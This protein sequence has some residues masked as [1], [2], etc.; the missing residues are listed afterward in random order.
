MVNQYIEQRG[1]LS[2]KTVLIT[3]CSSGIGWAT[4]KKL[5]SSG[6]RVFATARRSEDIS[7]IVDQGWHA[8]ELD[9]T[10]SDSI[11]HAAKTVLDLVNGEL[12][13]VV[14]NAGFGMPG[15][16]ED[17]SRA[18]LQNQFEVNLFGTIELT[19]IL[20]PYLIN[21]PRATIIYISSLVGRVSLPFMG[22]YSASKFALEAVADA[23]R[24]EL[25]MT[26]VRV[27]LIEPGPISTKFSSTC[28]NFGNLELNI[29]KS[30][31]ESLYK[32]YFKQRMT[33]GMSEDRFRLSPEDVAEKIILAICSDNPK[34]R[35]RVTIPA[36]IA[37]FIA[38]Y[39]P[40]SLRDRIMKKQ[41]NKR[42]SS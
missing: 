31:F 21:R 35:Y 19:N 18:A 6:W 29:N 41:V 27:V 16:I 40:V 24:I 7:R 5:G 2:Q 15:A 14:N 36:H 25:S 17:L 28:A 34:D 12:D 39:F 33:G 37:E 10:C 8:I 32:V 22:A 13:V 23:Q 38:R 26:P 42:F 4:A 30:R 9:L 3:G 1:N 20:M 11:K